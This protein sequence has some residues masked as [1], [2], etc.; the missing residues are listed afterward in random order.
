MQ[1]AHT[2]HFGFR[3]L[4]IGHMGYDYGAWWNME[5]GRLVMVMV[6]VLC[7]KAILILAPRW[8]L[9]SA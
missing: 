3:I 4:A 6:T 8:P 9:A 7:S 1:K 5:H 2:G